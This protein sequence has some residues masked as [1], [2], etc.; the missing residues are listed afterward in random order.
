VLAPT[1]SAWLQ[2]RGIH[3]AWVTMAVAFLAMLSASA[4]LGMPGVFLGPLGREFG[5]STDEVSSA[6]AVRYVLFGLMGPFAG[7]LIERFGLLRIVCA[8]LLLIAGGLLLATRMT[9][10]WHLFALWG[11]ML[12]V[13]SGLTALVLGA[14]VANRWFDKR[15]GLVMGI[16]TASTATGQLLFLPLTAVLIEQHGWRWAILPALLACLIVFGLVILFIAD[17]PG[18]LGLAAFGADLSKPEP[19]SGPMAAVSTHPFAVLRSVSGSPA[20]WVL[21]GTFFVCGLSTSGL[22]QT[23]FVSLC[24]DRGLAAVPAASVLAMIGAF[25]FVGTIASGWLSDR[26][27]N[28]KLLFW[29]YA[30]R[31]VSLLW[32]PHADYTVLGLSLFAMFYGLDWIATVPPTIRLASSIYGKERGPLVFGW[33]FAGHQIGSAVAAY[34]AGVIRT[35]TV[36]YDPALYGAGAVCLAA[37]LAIFLLRPTAPSPAR[38]AGAQPVPVRGQP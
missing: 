36:S 32:L 20:F 35:T 8:A 27:D 37:A 14:T 31:G 13:G 4:A 38:Q 21:A 1:L 2:R 16:L 9:A 18:D 7:S 11:V 30:L 25:D 33:I 29:Y 24:S 3:Y 23:H 12:G 22:I 26:Y 15:R 5:W 6:I 28:R 17:R 34:G 19:V 10:L